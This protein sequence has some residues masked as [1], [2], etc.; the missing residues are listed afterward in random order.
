MN[1]R[2]GRKER[3]LTDDIVAETAKQLVTRRQGL[4]GE[5]MHCRE[6]AG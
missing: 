4:R 5:T 3:K 2:M 1:G 6:A